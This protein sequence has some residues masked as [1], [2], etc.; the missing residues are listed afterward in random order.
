[1]DDFKQNLITKVLKSEVTKALGCTEVGLIG[2][3]VSLC[4]VK[5]RN[6]FV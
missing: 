1:M 2:Y 4:N 6:N 5:D 3:A